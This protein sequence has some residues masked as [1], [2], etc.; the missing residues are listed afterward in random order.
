MQKLNVLVLTNDTCWAEMLGKYIQKHHST[1]I[2]LETQ[3][4]E[5]CAIDCKNKAHDMILV[6]QETFFNEVEVECIRLNLTGEPET[7]E[8]GV[9]FKYISADQLIVR[10]LQLVRGADSNSQVEHVIVASSYETET[11]YILSRSLGRFKKNISGKSLLISMVNTNR[12]ET[13]GSPQVSD[14]FGRMIYYASQSK[15]KL[16]GNIEALTTMTD[17]HIHVVQKPYP[18]DASLFTKDMCI[19]LIEAL[20]EQS[21][22]SQII[23]HLGNA[24]SQGFSTLFNQATCFIWFGIDR[25]TG[26]DDS[27]QVYQDLSACRLDLKTIYLDMGDIKNRSAETEINQKKILTVYESLLRGKQ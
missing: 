12:T 21:Y 25:E 10:I 26:K 6:D 16:R 18:F 9:I 23:W 15:D 5:T 3:T 11:S 17:D 27:Y 19:N 20:N 22:F 13:L 2:I 24:F 1:E 7:S 4:D 8:G 14:P